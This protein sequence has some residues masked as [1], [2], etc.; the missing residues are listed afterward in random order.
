MLMAALLST[1]GTTFGSLL[2]AVTLGAADEPTLPTPVSSA[3]ST[4]PVG[5]AP[6]RTW[7]GSH[8]F[9][10]VQT[11]DGTVRVGSGIGRLRIDKELL[12]GDE[13]ALGDRLA[14]LIARA[15]DAGIMASE[16]ADSGFVLS[17]GVLTGLRLRSDK[18]MVI[19]EGVLTRDDAQ[20][21]EHPGTATALT[22]A[23]SELSASLASTPLSPLAQ[24]SLRTVLE[25]LAESDDESSKSTGIEPEFCRHLIRHGWLD[26]ILGERAKALDHAVAD[27]DA[28]TPVESWQGPGMRLEVLADPFGRRAWTLTTPARCA[29]VRPAPAPDYYTTKRFAKALLRV[30]LP[31]GAD[32]RRPGDADIAACDAGLWIED[33][34][35]AGWSAAGGWRGTEAGW[36]KRFPSGDHELGTALAN[37]YM[38][39][40]VMIQ[41]LAGDARLLVTAHGALRPPTGADGDAERFLAEAAAALPDVPHLA[42]IGSHLFNYSWD[43]PDPRQPLLMGAK[44]LCGDIHQ[45]ARQ[46]LATA[47]GGICRG[48]CDDL[49]ELYQEIAVRQGHNVIVMSLPRHLAASWAEKHDGVW[50]VA[51]L[52]TGPALEFSHA[53]LP[54]ALEAAYHHFDENAGFDPGQVSLSLRFA[55]EN[56]RSHWRLGWRIFSEPE[57]AKTMIE[58]QRDWYFHTYLRGISTMRA[59]LDAGDDDVAN[60]SELSGLYRRTGQWPD[61]IDYMRRSIER[62]HDRRASAQRSIEL[63]GLLTG[64]KRHAEA[65]IEAKRLSEV[66]FPALESSLGQ[67]LPRLAV[68]LGGS[69]DVRT[70]ARAQEE[71][72][73]RWVLPGLLQSQGQV[74]AWLRDR[75]DQATWDHHRDLS[76]FRQLALSTVNEAQGII[77]WL[78]PVRDGDDQALDSLIRLE[79]GW[80]DRIALRDVEEPSDIAW[81]YAFAGYF[82]ECAIGR[83]E[84]AALLAEAVP[85]AAPE[86]ARAERIGGIA[87]LRLD[88]P[89]IA[90]SVPYWWSVVARDVWGE[91]PEVASDRPCDRPAALADLAR[92]IAAHERTQAL[93]LSSRPLVDLSV[94]ARVLAAMLAQDRP[95]LVTALR[96]VAADHD[97]QLTETVAGLI[98]NTAKLLDAPW[99]D[100]VLSAWREEVDAK[101]FYFHIA[102]TAL[103]ADADQRALA[104]ARLAGARFADDQSFGEEQR[105]I[106]QVVRDR[107]KVPTPAPGK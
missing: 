22:T 47:A 73:Q 68:R 41:D 101:P 36:R 16:D 97:R 11:D 86:A 99:F 1:L 91:S 7:G 95:A 29:F 83:G 78:G 61:S 85:P 12:G 104:A 93:G 33:V 56:T 14:A 63:V 55:G 64:A 80:L 6:T 28:L 70:Q 30:G 94:Q 15:R 88:L 81:R 46:T 17:R 18:R 58:V 43:S 84:F 74:G 45:T 75:F 26:A 35:V 77:R 79:Q 72:L 25:H 9:T 107:A 71:I 92:L 82:Y 40:H 8:P 53:E 62:V 5:S 67:T 24:Q 105:F 65:A 13:E 42:L 34:E 21:L 2:G 106:E 44:D 31:A 3:A 38:P 90:I 100:Q 10:L 102:W 60:Y 49:A 37:G 59:M 89:W 19:E 51:V 87:Q 20:A 23:A 69:L 4:A 103:V 98:G 39:P 76:S 27:A 96:M 48:D 54:K 57:Y 32:P 50:T 52:Q 66:E